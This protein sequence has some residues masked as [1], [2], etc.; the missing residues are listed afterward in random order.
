MMAGQ[1]TAKTASP[2]A[3]RS[4]THQTFP[5][6]KEPSACVP[7]KHKREN[8]DPS[9][10]KK[11]KISEERPHVRK[12]RASTPTDLNRNKK[13]RIDTKENGEREKQIPSAKRKREPND[14]E[15]HTFVAK[16]VH[17]KD[18][19]KPTGGIKRKREI[20][21]ESAQT[22]LSTTEGPILR[23]PRLDP[24]PAAEW[25]TWNYWRIPCDSALNLEGDD[26]EL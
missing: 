11:L 22:E 15:D 16:K 25:N 4:L 23:I 5:T 17:S 2:I 1:V 26:E 24:E 21:A 8:E 20:T 9:A 10:H 18:P 13:R 14:A 3:L 7:V 6:F 12:H 19:E